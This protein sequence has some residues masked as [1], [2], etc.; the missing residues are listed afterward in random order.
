MPIGVSQSCV[1]LDGAA[2]VVRVAVK[3]GQAS[4]ST[5]ATSSFACVIITTISKSSTTSITSITT[6]AISIIA[7][8]SIS[9]TTS[10][11]HCHYH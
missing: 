7:T 6:S 8:T 3:R 9:L 4:V 5:I 10:S 11:A 2:I 1:V